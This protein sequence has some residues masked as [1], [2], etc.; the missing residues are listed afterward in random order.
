MGKVAVIDNQNTRWNTGNTL[1]FDDTTPAKT[2]E[3]VS[4]VNLATEGYQSI[5]AQLVV[6]FGDLADG[7]AIVKV[8][9]SADGG[10]T[11]DSIL[12]YEFDV[13][14]TVSTTKR[15]SVVIADVAWVE[16][17]VYNGNSAVQDITISGT[18]A[19]MR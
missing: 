3:G 14:F 7:N 12:A 2:V 6:A 16:I 10:T 8:R 9:T 19:G 13:A 18:Y 15:V 17:G 5:H 1:T 4:T 11:K